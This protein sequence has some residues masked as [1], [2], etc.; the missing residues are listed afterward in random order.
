MVSSSS[1]SEDDNVLPSILLL[2]RHRRL[3]RAVCRTMWT[4]SW[5]DR[6]Q[7]QG[8][9]ANLLKDLDA[10]D[11]EMFRQYHRL[12]VESFKTILE[13]V[14]SQTQNSDLAPGAPDLNRT[15]SFCYPSPVAPTLWQRYLG[16]T[17]S[18]LYR[19]PH[20]FIKQLQFCSKVGI[21]IAR[22]VSFE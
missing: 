3:A 14:T 8:V 13:I 10:E 6:R 1:E 19:L 17:H 7:R 21:C 16:I 15:Q 18:H 2:L 4:R 5:I 22:R 11:P 12:N 9:N 20:C